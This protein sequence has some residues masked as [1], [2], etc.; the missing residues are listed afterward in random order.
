MRRYTDPTTGETIEVLPTD[1]AAFARY[2]ATEPSDEEREKIQAQL[3]KNKRREEEQR[4]KEAKK[5]AKAAKKAAA[6]STITVIR[7][8]SQLVQRTWEKLTLG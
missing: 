6:P 1:S 4:A 8:T 7:E 3:E 2:G 5:A